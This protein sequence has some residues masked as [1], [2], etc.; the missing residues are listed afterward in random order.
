MKNVYDEFIEKVETR[1]RFRSDVKKG[2]LR[3][4]N[5]AIV[6]NGK[7]TDGVIAMEIPD[8]PLKKIEDLYGNYIKSIPSASDKRKLTFYAPTADDMNMED[9]IFGEEREVA[10]ARLEGF[11]ICL[12]AS[13]FKWKE[14]MGS[15]FW[16]SPN[17]PD[18]IILK[19]WFV[20]PE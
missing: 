7:Y 16:K 20:K 2:L 13:G 15:W 18:L 14:E 19:S 4:G 12:V 10:R 5:K 8:N 6:K 17:Y 1:K 3:I 11:V 9:L